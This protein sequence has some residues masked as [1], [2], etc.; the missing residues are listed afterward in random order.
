[1]AR[2]DSLLET[3][4]STP[5]NDSIDALLADLDKLTEKKQTVPA[6][7]VAAGEKWVFR[8]D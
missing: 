1:M 7:D 3:I 6:A 4:D 2:L 8:R 5:K